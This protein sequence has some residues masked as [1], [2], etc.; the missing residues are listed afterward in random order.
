MATLN[1]LR[2]LTPPG[3]NLA[4]LVEPPFPDEVD[5]G[6]LLKEYGLPVLAEAAGTVGVLRALEV[7][8]PGIQRQIRDSGKEWLLFHLVVKPGEG[9]IIHYYRFKLT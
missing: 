7:R 8:M 1:E 3:Y 4:V 5:A 6:E 9:G 2:R